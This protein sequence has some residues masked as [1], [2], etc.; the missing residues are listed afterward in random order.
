MNCLNF[1]KL[2]N[3]NGTYTIMSE[4]IE[5]LRHLLH[6]KDEELRAKDELL[7]RLESDLKEKE[8]QIVHLR[9]EIDKFRQVVQPITQKIITKQLSL[10]DADAGWE[11]E[12]KKGVELRTK[13]Q[14]ISAEPLSNR[15]SDEYLIMKT[16][17][18]QE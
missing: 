10:G 15:S 14:A 5:T 9:N 16:P 18:S 1:S 7:F 2:L 3:N 17:K 8:A 4:T 13:R 6:A 11:L 12:G